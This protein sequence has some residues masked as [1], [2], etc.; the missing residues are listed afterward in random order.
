MAQTNLVYH[1]T[2]HTIGLTLF[3]RAL[4]AELK[5]NKTNLL[6]QDCTEILSLVEKV[7]KMQVFDLIS[8]TVLK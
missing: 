8:N 7:I 5:C 1:L 6:F 3:R 4:D 2:A